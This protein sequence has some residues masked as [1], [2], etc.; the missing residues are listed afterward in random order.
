L[1]PRDLGSRAIKEKPTID[2]EKRVTEIQ[3]LYNKVREKIE[4]CNAMP[5]Y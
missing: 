4:I 2:A 1:T 3:E 5:N